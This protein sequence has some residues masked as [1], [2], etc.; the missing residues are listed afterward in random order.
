MGN[1]QDNFPIVVGLI[2]FISLSL[3]IAL[4]V[5]FGQRFHN[6]VLEVGRL[7]TRVRRM[8]KEEN[9]VKA[10]LRPLH[11]SSDGMI[12]FPIIHRVT[13]IGR[14]LGLS[15]LNLV[16]DQT[17]GSWHCTIYVDGGFQIEDLGSANGTYL[18][19]HLFRDKVMSLKD[20]DL[21]RIGNTEFMFLVRRSATT[22][23]EEKRSA[24]ELIVG[25]NNN[26]SSVDINGDAIGHD[27][28]S[29]MQHIE[30]EGGAYVTRGVSVDNGSEFI[31]RD[32]ANNIFHAHQVI[33]NMNPHESTAATPSA[34]PNS[35]HVEEDAKPK[36]KL[37]QTTGGVKGKT[38]ATTRTAE[39]ASYNEMLWYGLNEFDTFLARTFP[40][41]RGLIRI[42]DRVQIDEFLG[43]LAQEVKRY[44]VWMVRGIENLEVKEIRPLQDGVWLIAF[45]ECQIESIWI[46]RSDSNYRQFILIEC[47][48]M[49]SFGF[50]SREQEWE[51]AAWFIDRHIKR[52]E[53]DDGFAEIDGESVELKGRAEQ[54]VRETVQQFWF[55]GTAGSNITQPTNNEVVEQ[56]Y[57]DLLRTGT[58]NLNTLRPL[59]RLQLND[60]VSAML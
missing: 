24:Q 60:E 6:F 33:V 36:Q 8:P 44:A 12:D 59:N 16:D 45:I 21:I 43:Q 3:L 28:T 52:T 35:E 27:K 26:S 55:L 23:D 15:E 40:G 54:R 13:R 53:Y 25:T 46:Q 7:Q 39:V 30:T 58:V 10:Y 9:E 1:V 56:V 57:K 48:P 49:P 11:S 19:G 37:A 31:G 41:R 5:I 47:A 50:S 20:R 2:C 42:Q 4:I 38:E 22:E 32:K 17:V 18:N 51:D 34:V 29:S 14:D